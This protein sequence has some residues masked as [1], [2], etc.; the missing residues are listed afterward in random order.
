MSPHDLYHKSL[1]VLKHLATASMEDLPTARLHD[2]LNFLTRELPS[3]IAQNRSMIDVDLCQA[4]H[5]ISLSSDNHFLIRGAALYLEDFFGKSV[6]IQKRKT[7]SVQGEESK[8]LKKE[9]RYLNA[10]YAFFHYEESLQ[11]KHQQS[12]KSFNFFQEQTRHLLKDEQ[13]IE[14]QL[15]GIGLIINAATVADG[16]IDHRKAC[17]ELLD[18]ILKNTD[19]KWSV[20]LMAARGINI[21]RIRYGQPANDEQDLAAKILAGKCYGHL[22]QYLDLNDLGY[23]EDIEYR[24]DP[25]TREIF[26]G[27]YVAKVLTNNRYNADA[28][29]YFGKICDLAIHS[30]KDYQD[31]VVKSCCFKLSPFNRYYMDDEVIGA[32]EKIAQ[33]VFEYSR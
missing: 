28:H 9:D 15:V 12:N 1:F 6:S 31:L 11:T 25:F 10:A 27:D 32:R 8:Q 14:A 5:E 22:M 30:P 3:F 4:L 2:L 23:L 21:L 16:F 17:I 24:S 33:R 20:Y 26:L 18:E 29:K 7:I 19:N 13:N